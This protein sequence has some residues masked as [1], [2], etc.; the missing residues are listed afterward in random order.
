[1]N[2]IKKVSVAH[3]EIRCKNSPGEVKPPKKR[4]SFLNHFF[5]AFGKGNRVIVQ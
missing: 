1:M 2:G 5:M 3:D 4:K